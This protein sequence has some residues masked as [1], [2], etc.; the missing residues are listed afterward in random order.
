MRVSAESRDEVLVG[1]REDPFS[2]AVHF[3]LN[4][5][6]QIAVIDSR[7]EEVYSYQRVSDVPEEFFPVDPEL[8]RVTQLVEHQ[9]AGT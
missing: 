5:F 8:I 3:C 1:V 6:A 9:P 2:E 7:F 4:L